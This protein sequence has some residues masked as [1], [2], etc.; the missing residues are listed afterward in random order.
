MKALTF[1]VALAAALGMSPAY[2]AQN[3]ANTSQKGSLLI[4]PAITID[5]EDTS[6]TFIEISNDQNTSVHIECIYVSET[7]E[8]VGF[9]FDLTGKQTASWDVKTQAGDRV[10]PPP[11]PVGPGVFPG[12]RFRGALVC[13]AVTSDS[14]NQIAFNHLTGTATV[15]ALND[16]DAAQKRQAFRYDAWSF[17]ARNGA[18][19]PAADNTIQ[20]LPGRLNLTGGGAGT[21]DA[22][23]A[24][25]VANFMPNGARLGNLSTLD[26]DL[27]VVSCNQDLRGSFTLHFTRLQFDVWN[28]KEQS[29]HNT[30]QCVDSVQ[31]VGL[32][33]ID[34]SQLAHPENFDF[35]TLG[36]PNARFQVRGIASNSP[37]PAG[38]EAAGLLGVLASSVRLPGNS[39]LEDAD[40]GSTTQ[41]AGS[42]PGFVLWDTGTPVQ[43][44]PRSRK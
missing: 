27:S 29:F 19:L 9:N 13:F 43:F 28:A 40:V 16:T 25:N 32:S 35:A 23:P 5:P 39:T 26:N 33:G 4:W 15:L 12:N 7:K 34:N 2:A 17:V 38:T 41:G 36:T 6:D 44:T 14:L 3:V 42:T 18:G 37:C 30:Y 22:C 21:Y 1:S 10:H 8:R 11:F 24:Y 20:G 31:T